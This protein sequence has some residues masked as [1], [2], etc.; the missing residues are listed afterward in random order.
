MSEAMAGIYDDDD[1]EIL[2][3]QM[4]FEAL[5]IQENKP[6]Q[7]PNTKPIILSQKMKDFFENLIERLILRQHITL[8]PPKLERENPGDPRDCRCNYCNKNSFLELMG[9]IRYGGVT[10]KMI[11]DAIKHRLK[12]CIYYVNPLSISQ[13]VKKLLDDFCSKHLREYYYNNHTNDALT[14]LAHDYISNTQLCFLNFVGPYI[15]TKTKFILETQM[16]NLNLLEL[17][18]KKHVENIKNVE[19]VDN[20]EKSSDSETNNFTFTPVQSDSDDY[21]ESEFEILDNLG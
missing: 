21:E 5:T 19:N 17:F 4:L 9:P 13:D 11:N 3:L 7:I 18:C 15:D 6:R 10:E 20:E 8:Y 12:R 14:H 1:M 2:H 16:K